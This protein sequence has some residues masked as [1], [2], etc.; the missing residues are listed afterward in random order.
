MNFAKTQPNMYLNQTINTIEPLT[1]GTRRV[2]G[3][4]VQRKQ[5]RGAAI[6]PFLLVGGDVSSEGDGTSV[7]Y[8]SRRVDRGG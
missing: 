8:A 3:P 4:T 6:D 1:G 7:L 2:N 5:S